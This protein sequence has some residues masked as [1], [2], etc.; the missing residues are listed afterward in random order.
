MQNVAIKDLVHP[1]RGGKRSSI[2][3]TPPARENHGS[4][5]DLHLLSRSVEHIREKTAALVKWAANGVTRQSRREDFSDTHSHI[6]QMCVYDKLNLT[7]AEHKIRSAYS[8]PRQSQSLFELW[9]LIVSP[10]CL[11]FMTDEVP[12]FLT[13]LLSLESESH[14][15]SGSEFNDICSRLLYLLQLDCMFQTPQCC[16]SWLHHKYFNS[17]PHQFLC[18]P[19]NEEVT[20]VKMNLW[21]NKM[22]KE[23]KDYCRKSKRGQGRR[24]TLCSGTERIPKVSVWTM[25]HL[26]SGCCDS[27]FAAKLSL[28][29]RWQENKNKEQQWR[30]ALD[31]DSQIGLYL[32]PSVTLAQPLT[33]SSVICER[34]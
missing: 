1:I 15:S 27:T 20:F 5:S 33:R 19:C 14:S 9:L 16:G 4:I 31:T 24:W 2:P 22:L 28:H 17:A 18:A 21:N 10:L 26:S 29:A 3:K 6:I 11:F 13:V 34:G 23:L 7:L 8:H 25:F 12:Q 32:V 30:W